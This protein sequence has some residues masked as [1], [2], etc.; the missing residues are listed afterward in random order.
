MKKKLVIIH[1]VTGAIGSACFSLFTVQSN[2]IVYGIS[3]KGTDFKEFCIDGKLP[4]ATLICSISS[5]TMHQRMATFFAKAI[6]A[7]AF[8]EICYIHALGVYP[9]ELDKNGDRIVHCD[10]NGDGIDDRCAALTRSM[11]YCFYANLGHEL[12]KT[13]RSFIFGGLA[14]KHEPRA[15]MSWWKTMKKLKESTIDILEKSDLPADR[16]PKISLV[17]I[18]SVLCPNEVI[19]R[20]FVFSATDADPIYWLQ[21][22]EVASFLDTLMKIE[23]TEKFKEYELFKNKPGFDSEYYTDEKFTPRKVA[24]IYSSQLNKTT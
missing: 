22:L 14:D 20:P 5:E 2:T 4:I 9:F 16:L 13:V 21:P 19:N 7:D 12:K 10:N 17:N 6:Q 24:E 18:S 15:H 23:Q 8:E 11:F 1:G 3:R